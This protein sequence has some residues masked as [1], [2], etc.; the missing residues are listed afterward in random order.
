MP[1]VFTASFA[2]KHIGV[3]MV[4]YY[5]KHIIF[6]GVIKTNNV[7]IYAIFTELF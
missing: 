5:T 2:V 3:A 4:V 7:C 1:I 6:C